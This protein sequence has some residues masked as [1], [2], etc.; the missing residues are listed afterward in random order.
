MT[1]VK[2]S[3][4]VT[5]KAKAEPN[6]VSLATIPDTGECQVRV[7]YGLG[8]GSGVMCIKEDMLRSS[9]LTLTGEYI[10][11]VSIPNIMTFPLSTAAK[12]EFKVSTIDTIKVEQLKEHARG[13]IKASDLEEEIEIPLFMPILVVLTLHATNSEI[14]YLVLYKQQHIKEDMIKTEWIKEYLTSLVAGIFAICKKLLIN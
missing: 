8:V 14:N 10:N 3:T 1:T 9:F 11:R 12:L 5:A 13:W 7:I 2:A 4:R 6:S